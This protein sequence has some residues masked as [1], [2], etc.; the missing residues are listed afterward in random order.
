MSSKNPLV[1]VAAISFALFC[2]CSAPVSGQDGQRSVQPLSSILDQ[3]Q[4]LWQLYVETID[5][6][7][8]SENLAEQIIQLRHKAG[9]ASH[10]ALARAFAKN[11]PLLLLDEPTAG[12]DL[13]NER[14]IM[15]GFTSL[16]WREFPL[17]EG[18]VES[19]DLA[20]PFLD[21]CKIGVC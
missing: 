16:F 12:L 2:I 21:W 3:M 7:A 1:L 14:L 18:R 8:R 11:A 9:M 19:D 5:N 4:S 15:E 13:E 6:P 20:H 17:D 10:S